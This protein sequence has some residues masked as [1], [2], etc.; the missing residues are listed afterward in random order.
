MSWEAEP[1]QQAI[2]RALHLLA[3]QRGSEL[4]TAVTPII[5][6]NLDKGRMQTFLEQ[7]DYSPADYVG[8]VADKYEQWHEHVYAVQIEKRTEIWQPLYEQLQ[9][10]AF[11]LLPR[12]GYPNYA[13][14]DDKTQRAQACAT[15]AALVLIGAYFPYDVNFEPWAYV[16]LQ[17]VT[18]KQMNRR[19][20]PRLEAEAQEVEVDAWH[21]WL[22][23]LADPAG[24]EQQHLAELRADLLDS[25]TQLNSKARQQFILLYYFESQSFEQIATQMNKSLNA[26][27]KLHSDALENLRKIWR[28]NRDKYE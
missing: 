24:Q 12:L 28:Q 20:K 27:Y 15:E 6:T 2:E 25:I 13:S 21:D 17:N 1:R 18:R 7:Q 16:L 26:L 9:R 8:R 10:W 4:A 23:N 22:H 11:H 19:I 14:H 5:F 3:E